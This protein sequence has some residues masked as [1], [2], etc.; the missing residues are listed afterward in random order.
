M[1][2][3]LKIELKLTNEQ[4][5][6][7]NKTIGTERFIYN[8]YIKY[9]Q[10]QYEL[11]NKFVSA[12]D[13]SKYINNVYLPSNPDKKWIKDV[14][15]KSVKQA[16]IY[17]EK[18]FKNFFKGL[19]SFP[20]FKKKGKNELGAYF[21]KDN[22]TDFEFYRHK[23]K[24][25]SLKFVRVKEYGYI[26][27]NANIKS[28]TISKKTDRY[29]LSLIMEV[30]DIVKTE[31]TNTKGLGI[32]LG[33]KDTA[34]CSDGRIFK[35][36][37][38]TKK[39]KKIKKKIKREQRKMARS[40]EYSKSNKI[41]LKECKNFNKKKLKVQRLFYRLNCIRDN[42][43]NKMVDEITRTKLK[44]ITIEDLKVSNMMKNKHLSKAI[45]EQNFFTIRTKLIN[46]CKERNI[47][48]RLVD[49]FYPSSK[50]CS[51]CGSIKKDLKLND[52][53][54]KC[55]NCGLEIDR[56]YNASINLEKA[57]VYKVIA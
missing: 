28:G 4:K 18:A 24:I 32:D 15:S 41:K 46:K 23:I 26:P 36:I 38:K 54:Y 5:I 43:N 30:E 17:G 44:Y 7:V 1:Y 55:S 3:A 31:N 34:I 48:L 39:I 49:T 14:S 2:K 56:D 40:V 45:Q 52:R 37:N 8:E 21:V 29:F 11:G 13:F 47:E 20:V 57:K 16:M 10:E 42:Y 33:I 22:K 35:N 51:C 6:Q 50:T 9:N 53:I 27:K 25:P 12:F 19:S